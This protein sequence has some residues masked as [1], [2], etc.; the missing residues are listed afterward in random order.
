MWSFDVFLTE[1]TKNN[2]KGTDPFLD[3]GISRSSNSTHI[4]DVVLVKLN[5]S[6]IFILKF[7]ESG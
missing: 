1:N 6:D 7:L 4:K 2:F 3:E 5:E